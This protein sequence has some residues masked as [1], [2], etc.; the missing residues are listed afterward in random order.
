MK[1]F[2]LI[3][4]LITAAA[5][6]AAAQNKSVYTKTDTKSCRTISADPSHGGSYEGEC[7]GVRG[8]K[9]RL[10]EGDIR[11]SINIITPANKKFELDFWGFYGGFSSIGEKVEW[12]TSN[13]I[14]IALIARYNVADNDDPRSSHSYL[15]VAKISGESS[16]VTDIVAPEGDQNEKARSLADSALEKPCRPKR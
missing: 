14:P 1:R 10:I 2:L 9:I 13:G 16:C 6:F 5:A 15:M 7:K 3:F 12:R 4:I 11:Q 8:Y